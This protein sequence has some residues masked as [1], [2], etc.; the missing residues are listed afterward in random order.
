MEHE[1]SEEVEKE[2]VITPVSAAEQVSKDV[3]LFTTHAK[4]QKRCV[5]VFHMT[6]LCII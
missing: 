3:D 4:M 1:N 2:E 6:S 5:T